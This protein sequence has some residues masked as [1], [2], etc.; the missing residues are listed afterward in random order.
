MFI[1]EMA[2]TLP[3]RSWPGEGQVAPV[4]AALLDVLLGQDQHAAGSS[5]GVV[6][7]HALVGIGDLN[8][9]PHDVAGRVELAA[10]L[11][12]RV[13]EVAD[14]V[15]VGGPEQ[16]RELEVLLA[17]WNLVEVHD[18]F[19]QLLV[20]HRRLPDLA[21]EVDVLQNAVQRPVLMLQRL[22]RLVELAADTVVCVVADL[23]P[24][25]ADGDVEGL[26]EGRRL[27]A[28]FSLSL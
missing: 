14:Q 9:E 17:Q 2:Q 20:R 11:A 5:A 23:L 12:G 16:V 22:K 1:L 24:T 26:V 13:R 27:G 4:A 6:D 3:S 25:R 10:L 21:G 8:H 19:T 28:L 18:Q 15:L 7:A